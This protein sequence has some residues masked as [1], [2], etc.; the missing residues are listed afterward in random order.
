MSAQHPL[1]FEDLSVGDTF[2]SDEHTLDE[3]QIVAFAREFD[4]QPFH[5][6]PD[7][8][9]HSFFQGL[10]ASG[11]HTASISMKLLVQSLPLGSGVI[12]AGGE[13]AWPRPTRPGDTLHVVSRVLAVAASASKPDRGRVTVECQTFNQHD[14]LCQRLVARLVVMRRP[15]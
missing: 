9:E 12:G 4:P 7:A 15:Q 13:V 11:W 3:A 8:A 5:T 2:R 6:D 1:Y 14:E 10:A